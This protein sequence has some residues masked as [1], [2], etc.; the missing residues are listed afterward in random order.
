RRKGWTTRVADGE[1]AREVGYFDPFI[2][3]RA[4]DVLQ[5]D[6]RAFGFTRQWELSRRLPADSGITLAPHNWG[7]F[8][9]LYMQLVLA[10]GVDNVL[11]AEQDP[12]SS[13]LFERSAFEFKE[14][15]VR[16]PDTPGCGLVLREDVFDRQYKAAAW[17]VS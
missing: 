15:K 12:S 8:L 3:K 13:D 2:A 4:L 10:R 9:G 14:G 11:M 7:S 5:P 6:M 17:V 16:V 1:S